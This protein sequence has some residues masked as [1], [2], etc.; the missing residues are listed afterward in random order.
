MKERST[1]FPLAAFFW[2][3]DPPNVIQA[4]RALA[5]TSSVIA[6]GEERAKLFLNASERASPPKK[7]ETPCAR[8]VCLLAHYCGAVR[9]E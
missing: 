8:L 1:L 9:T 2:L 7:K 3:M 5:E 6:T 4:A